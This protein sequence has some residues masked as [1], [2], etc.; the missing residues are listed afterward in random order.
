MRAII[1]IELCHCRAAHLYAAD[2]IYRPNLIDLILSY[3][4]EE[5][6]T[7]HIIGCLAILTDRTLLL[8][9]RMACS[10]RTSFVIDFQIL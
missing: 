6:R 10:L 7:R 4:T 1:F 3:C 5:Y 2:D 9:M 8:A